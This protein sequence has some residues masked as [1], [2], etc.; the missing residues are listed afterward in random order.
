MLDRFKVAP[1]DQVRVSEKALRE[2]VAAIFAKLGLTAEDAALGA[3]VLVMT[4]LRGVDSHGV[5]NMLRTYVEGY[6]KGQLNPRPDWRVV[7]ESPATATIDGDGGLGI[8]LGPKAMRKAIEKARLVG[9]GIVTMYNGRHLGAVGHHAMLAAR[10]D[11]IGMCMTA[12]QPSVVP[13]F[14]AQARFGTNPISIA[15]PAKIHPPALF[16]AATCSIANNK[17]RLAARL[18]S[19]LLPGWVTDLEGNPIM[20]ETPPRK[21]GEYFLLPLGATREMG[22][23]KGYGLAMMVEVLSS[24]LSGVLPFGMD[25]SSGNKH[26]FAAYNIAAFTDVEKFKENMDRM[27]Q[28]LRETKPA[29]GHERVLYP[30]LLEYE[31]EEERRAHGIPLHREVVQWFDQ[32]TSE[33]GIPPL[34]R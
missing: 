17:V 29:P 1:A 9:V 25:R 12:T 16:D 2:T 22:S 28:W 23:H 19:N 34:D 33:F 15:A 20:N 27:L 7:R 21:R 6:R 3:N 14:G 4:D 11:M 30:G 26:Y 31:E 24:M 18:G 5:S 32:I 13:T 10:E 8:I